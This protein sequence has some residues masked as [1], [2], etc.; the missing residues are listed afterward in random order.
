M[1]RRTQAI[2]VTRSAL[3]VFEAHRD[4]WWMEVARLELAELL[5]E[6]DAF[7]A[8]EAIL[9]KTLATARS[10]GDTSNQARA[11]YRLAECPL[12]RGQ[13]GLA[14]SYFVQ[15]GD[16]YAADGDL[17]RRHLPAWR[18][19]VALH[20]ADL[21]H[22]AQLYDDYRHAIAEV[23]YR[24]EFE[25]L[26]IIPAMVASRAGDAG[27]WWQIW[28]GLRRLHAESWPAGARRDLA[29]CARQLESPYRDAVEALVAELQRA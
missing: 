7:D 1:G 23:T 29:A 6:V 25:W 2:E 15:A 3:E 12:A 19:R 18:A 8:A 22:A 24:D 14:E 28:D 17:N 9:E 16:L 26:G 4:V 27:R 21:D 5:I 10:R 11:L 20:R 13:L